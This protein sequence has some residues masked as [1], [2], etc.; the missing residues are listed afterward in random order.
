MPWYS[1]LKRKDGCHP[2][3][4]APVKAGPGLWLCPAFQ[5]GRPARGRPMVAWS[6]G[7]TGGVFGSS[8]QNAGARGR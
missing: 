8:G 4:W 2:P 1:V 6:C 5:G 3:A 7:L